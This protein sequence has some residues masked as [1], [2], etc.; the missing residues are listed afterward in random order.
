MKINKLFLIAL[1]FNFTVPALAQK[2]LEKPYTTWSKEEAMKVLSN[3][4]WADQYQSEAGLAAVAQQQARRD[5]SDNRLGGSERGSSTRNLTPPPVVIRL[6]SALP[7][8][9]AVVRMQQLQSNYD[10]MSAD[11]RARFDE[12]AKNFLNCKLCQDYYI[13]TLTKFK[14]NSSGFGIDDGLFQT[15]KF[16]NLKGNV[17]LVNDKGEKRELVQFTPPKAAGDSAVFFFKRIDEKGAP[18]LTPETKSFKFVFSND[19]LDNRNPYSPFVPRNFEFKVAKMV[20]DNKVQ[21]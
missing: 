17:W 2:Y 11:D 19:F 21:F 7:I 10:R 4:P 13:V 20:A 12:S 16:D 15:M 14:D 1:L 18:L 5:Q 3:S 6:Q 9:Q 8:R